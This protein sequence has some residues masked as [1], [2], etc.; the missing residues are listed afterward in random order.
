[1]AIQS[2][3]IKL[4]ELLE[5][6][7]ALGKELRKELETACQQDDLI[8][9]ENIIASHKYLVNALLDDYSKFDSFPLDKL[10]QDQPYRLN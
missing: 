5:L 3:R 1:M 4:V 10:I 8:T 2:G 9:V 6:S 7:E